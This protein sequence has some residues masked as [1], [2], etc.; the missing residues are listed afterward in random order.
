MCYN[1]VTISTLKS[2]L[3]TNKT[4]NSVC[5]RDGCNFPCYKE[6]QH[7]LTYAYCSHRC[8][9]IDV[10]SKDQFILTSI[11]ENDVDFHQVCSQ[12]EKEIK[13]VKNGKAVVFRISVSAS[14]LQEYHQYLESYD[15]TSCRK[16]V[17]VDKRCYKSGKN[18]IF[19]RKL[20]IDIKKMSLQLLSSD[21][22]SNPVDKWHTAVVCNTSLQQMKSHALTMILPR[23]LVYYHK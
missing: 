4:T 2:G 7:G 19:F 23:F 17:R 15:Y 13:N 6:K 3:P 5:I 16:I 1:R 14:A 9:K 18:M 20:F 8:G 21:I 11:T 12:L 22:Q 10:S